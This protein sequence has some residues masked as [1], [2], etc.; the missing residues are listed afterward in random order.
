VGDLAYPPAVTISASPGDCC[1]GQFVGSISGFAQN[2][3]TDSTLVVLY[4]KTDVYY[5]QPYADSRG[6]TA[7]HCPSGAFA[8]STRGGCRYSAVLAKRSWTPPATLT[9]LPAVGGPILA[10]ATSLDSLPPPS[11][12]L[13]FAGFTWLVKSSCGLLVGPGPNI[14][15]DS[16]H[17][18]S[19]D[20]QGRLHL[21]LTHRGPTWSAAEVYS[22]NVLGYGTYQFTVEG[23][24]DSLDP[25]VVLGCFSYS[26]HYPTDEDEIDVEF[27][28]WGVATDPN[29]QYVIQPYDAPGHRHRFRMTLSGTTSSHQFTWLTTRVD[30]ASWN[31]TLETPGDTL[32]TWS[33]TDAPSVPVADAERMRFNLWLF[34]GAPP[35]DG[36]DVEVVISD[37]RFESA[38]S[39]RDEDG[40]SRGISLS[41]P[42][43]TPARG[44][45]AYVLTL[46]R[47]ERVRIG[48]YDAAGHALGAIREET[49]AAGA[50]RLEWNAGAA[51]HTSGVCVLRVEVG[52]VKLQRR[53]ALLR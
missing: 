45:I 34:G 32:H 25:N 30:F 2:V 27:S 35:S 44:V 14:F 8:N 31:G 38:T 5:I 39:V 50:H 43:P 36:K 1:Y 18:V 28:R 52:G 42:F 37:F 23:A 4:A 9:M 7:I 12:T 11:D 24:I 20:G 10:T 49:L 48:V 15:S 16:Y 19:V 26:D 22:A 41:Q 21:H 29:A 33:F 40:P 3:N 47:A 17:N 6:R 13:S 53:F 51:S 46:P